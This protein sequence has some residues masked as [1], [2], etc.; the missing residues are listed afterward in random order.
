M[1][2]Q[3]VLLECL[4]HVGTFTLG[5][6]LPHLAITYIVSHLKQSLSFH[7]GLFR[8]EGIVLHK[9]IHRRPILLFLW[10][11]EQ[12]WWTGPVILFSLQIIIVLNLGTLYVSDFHCSLELIGVSL[13]DI[14]IEFLR[15]CFNDKV[16]RL[17]ICSFEI[18]NINVLCIESINYIFC[19]SIFYPLLIFDILKVWGCIRSTRII[20]IIFSFLIK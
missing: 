1:L 10:H 9:S 3:S 7:L 17:R 11:L 5:D 18:W 12:D 13:S 19:L 8:F 16:V 20:I 15:L 2:I 4:E 14:F 6:L